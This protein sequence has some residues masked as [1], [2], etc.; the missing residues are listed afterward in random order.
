MDDA[1]GEA[2]DKVARMLDLGYP[3]VQKLKLWQNWAA[4]HTVSTSS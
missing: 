2:F 4:N 3:E 1:C